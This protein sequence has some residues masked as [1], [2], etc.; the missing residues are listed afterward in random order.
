M[1]TQPSISTF[2]VKFCLFLVFFFARD[3]E[4]RVQHHF[5]MVF[6]SCFLHFRTKS[7]F[8]DQS[9][10]SKSRAYM[11]ALQN[12]TFPA[13]SFKTPQKY[14]CTWERITVKIDWLSWP[15]F[16]R[17]L[18]RDSMV[19][20]SFEPSASQTQKGSNSPKAWIRNNT[21]TLTPWTRVCPSGL[22]LCS[23]T[24]ISSCDAQGTNEYT[25]AVHKLQRA[26]V[27]IPPSVAC[28]FWRDGS[29]DG[30]WWSWRCLLQSVLC[31]EEQGVLG[32]DR[33][34][35]LSTMAALGNPEV[36]CVREDDL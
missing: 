32:E 9:N 36:H 12:T 15:A 14:T 28:G 27:P 25:D 20:L 33:G 31:G 11:H 23:G 10:Q 34:S 21:P 24:K 2:Y 1:R 29:R 3:C 35:F 22:R 8:F 5:C 7:P 6:L 17:D 26:P 30:D 13:S 18:I 19:F 4:W 16:V